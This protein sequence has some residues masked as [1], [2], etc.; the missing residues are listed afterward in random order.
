MILYFFLTL[1]CTI[2]M[3]FGLYRYFGLQIHQLNLKLDDG[4]GYF[5]ISVLLI[6]FFGSALAYYVGGVLGY[7]QNAVQEGRL[8]AVIMLNVVVALVAL[9][10]GLMHFKEGERY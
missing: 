7:D 2:G 10:Y 1:A 5:L 3:C 6:T 8:G 9:T 4:R